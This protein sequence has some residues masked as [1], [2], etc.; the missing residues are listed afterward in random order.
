MNLSIHAD[1]AVQNIFRRRSRVIDNIPSYLIAMKLTIFMIVALNVQV[2]ANALA[3]RISLHLKNQPMEYA[4]NELQ[5]QSGYAVIYNPEY[6]KITH[7]VTLSVKDAAVENA[8][9]LIFANQPVSY[10]LERGVITIIPDRGLPTAA[11]DGHR[12]AKAAESRILG[13][14]EVRGRV[15]DSLGQPL[16]GAS[17]RVIDAAGQRTTRQTTADENGYF[18]LTEVPDNA[19]LEVTYVGHV[20]RQVRAAA[21]MG[22][23]V[24]Q[25]ESAGLDEVVVTA[26]GISRSKKAVGYAVQEVAGEELAQSRD[27]N[28]VNAL[29]GKIAGVQVTNSGGAVG[30]SSRIVIRGNN[31]F[32][33]N[34][35]LFV[36]DGVP[37]MNNSTSVTRSAGVDYGN[38]AADIDPNNI[39]S[40][41][42]LKGANAAALYGSRAANGVIL[43]TTKKGAG[44]KLGIDV[45]SSLTA[46][47]VYIMPKYQNEYGQGLY[48]SEYL[49]QLRQPDMAYQD[50]ARTYSYNYVDG[51]GGGVNDMIDES[52]GPRLDAG[53][54]IDQ[55]F[56]D[57]QPWIAHPDNVKSFFDTGITSDNN[58]SLSS[59]GEHAFGRLSLSNLNVTG[60]LPNT[61]LYQ[62]TVNFSGTLMPS[63]RF[64]AE[65][66]V[67][68]LKRY[69]DNLARGQYGSSENPFMSVGGWFGRQ[70]DMGLL[71]QHWAENDALGNPYNWQQGV[72]NPYLASYKNTNAMNKGRVFGN[73]NATFDVNDWLSLKGVV[74]TDYYDEFRQDVTNSRSTRSRV[75]GSFGQTMITSSETNA[76]VLLLAKKELSS[77]FAIDGLIGANIRNNKYRSMWVNAGELTVPDLY[78]ISN[79]KG[80]VSSSTYFS[81]K[82]TQS[83]YASANLSY[84]NYLFLSLTGRNDWSSTLPA[85]N[86]SFFY[87]SAT[88]GY[89]FTDGLDLGSSVLSYGKVRAGWAQV[90]NDTDPYRTVA[91]YA[92]SSSTWNGV[93]FY[94]YTRQIPPLNLKP[95]ITSSFEVGTELRFWNDRLWLDATYYHMAT[96]N[97][98]MSVDVSRTTGFGSSLINAGNIQNQGVEIQLGGRPVDKNGG[99]RWDVNVNWAANRNKVVELYP[100]IES[101]DLG[102]ANNV[103]IQAMPGK[104]FGQIIGGAYQRDG[105]GRIVVNAQ[106][107]PNV[108]SNQ[109][110]GNILPRWTGGVNNTLH[111]KN[112]LLSFLVDMRWGGD[113]FSYTTWHNLANGTLPATTANGV[114]E[115]G[116]I[117]AGVKE[118]GSVNDIRISAED[119]FRGGYVWDLHEN[120]IID[121]S[122]IK[123]REV[124]LGYT[125]QLKANK[126]LK[127]ATFSLVGRNLALLYTHKSNIAHIDPETGMG[128]GN[129]GLGVEVYQIPPT[130]SVGLK[131]Q[132]GF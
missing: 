95:E 25:A 46:D 126:Y 11:K 73:V 104:P 7:P 81:E 6:L 68:Y 29:S 110:L 21:T 111:Y 109:V 99:L 13:F 38:G 96:K 19:M 90:G 24:L 115:N 54:H 124:V 119:Y 27:I 32:G 47:N 65:V 91:T 130:R 20:A 121:G 43:I 4:L 15:V 48:G 26:L 106:G 3:Q 71:K 131:V 82:E 103:I 58:I 17:I 44:A 118:D 49:W 122:Y 33:D 72:D 31:S 40:V 132:L 66:N 100:G 51:R 39:E 105:D 85:N 45:S 9:K 92:P 61:E 86:R 18:A 23:I 79:V 10:T 41:S 59:A 108:V 87:P 37:V 113:F 62:N 117:V 114:R 55:F 127:K 80:N 98:I 50:Y 123:L 74:G 125:W 2:S 69:S 77:A 97:Q 63:K 76:D 22:N 94:S 12:G 112:L 5:R 60:S 34:Q 28:L 70:V 128:V 56:G 116:M 53:L 83:V 67:T 102:P 84:N 14:P 101:L 129:N 35:P 89:V 78:T 88:L 64:R 16:A 1:S 8:L 42:V 52:W 107:V 75:G 120:S 36:V 30:S 93:T 57:D